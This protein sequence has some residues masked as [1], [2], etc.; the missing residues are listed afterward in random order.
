VI[1][2]KR[3]RNLLG[4]LLVWAACSAPAQAATLWYNGNLDNRDSWLNQTSTVSPGG[5]D[6]RTYDDFI[7][8]VGETFTITSAYTNDLESPFFSYTPTTA[9]YQILKGVSTGNGGTTVATGDG[10]ASVTA[11]GRTST[12]L[13]SPFT[14]TE[15]TIAVSGLNIVLG[16]GTYW[17]SV[18]PDTDGADAYWYNDTTSGASA[19]GTPPGN[20]GNSYFSSAYLGYSFA[21]VGSLEGG[22]NWD[23]SMGII[24]T[25]A[26]TPEPS[27]VTLVVAAGFCLAAMACCRKMMPLRERS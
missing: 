22:G 6:G 15:Y 20:D 17:L 12:T 23:F 5:L 3:T 4:V 8:P 16:S 25:F 21:S 27:S 26:Q 24:G 9:S 7:V 1:A 19:V 14:A 11:T 13:F 10:T 2:L 18:A